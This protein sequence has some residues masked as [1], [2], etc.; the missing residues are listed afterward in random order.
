M[1]QALTCIST[2]VEPGLG[3]GRE[4][5]RA[6]PT[7]RV[8]RRLRDRQVNTLVGRHLEIERHERFEDLGLE[9]L[10][11]RI[12]DPERQGPALAIGSELQRGGHHVVVSW[13]GR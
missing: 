7:W 9:L 6:R 13:C 8:K 2:S 12:L 3:T 10:R 11:G 4:D 5:Q 1:P